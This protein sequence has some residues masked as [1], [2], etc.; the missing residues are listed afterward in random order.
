MSLESALTALGKKA[1]KIGATP[2]ASIFNMGMMFDGETRRLTPESRVVAD[3]ELA[4]DRLT[5]Q[6]KR[7][8]RLW[9]RVVRRGG[10]EQPPAIGCESTPGT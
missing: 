3:R 2:I 1:E 9:I 4:G 10:F 7:E 8:L 5:A 6:Q